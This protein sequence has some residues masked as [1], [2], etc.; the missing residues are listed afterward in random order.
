MQESGIE[1]EI[2]RQLDNKEYVKAAKLADRCKDAILRD[3]ICDEGIL[4]Y[5][6]HISGK[7]KKTIKGHMGF[8]AT[9]SAY[10]ELAALYGL[11]E[12]SKSQE[13]CM[14]LSR[15]MQTAYIELART[16]R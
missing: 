8:V 16:R 3:A 5:Y 15:A 11:K 1:S 7:E 12:D 14:E 10:K 6:G 4:Y 2:A 13:R 9:A